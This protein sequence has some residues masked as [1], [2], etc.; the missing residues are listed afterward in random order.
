MRRVILDQ[1]KLQKER[2]KKGKLLEAINQDIDFQ[3]ERA[4][5]YQNKEW[6][7]SPTHWF[8]NNR[9]KDTHQIS[10]Y[11]HSHK[12]ETMEKYLE[13]FESRRD[14]FHSIT[15][16]SAKLLIKLWYAIE[17]HLPYNFK[18]IAS[19]KTF[20]R[21]LLKD[22]LHQDEENIKKKKKDQDQEIKNLIQERVKNSQF[23]DEG[24]EVQDGWL[25][26]RP[27]GSRRTENRI[28]PIYNF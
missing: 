6:K 7:T 11:Q 23:D 8:S 26:E 21:K 16:Y 3:I 14:D 4:T 5:K 18:N 24:K 28:N 20:L 25:S 1:Q 22:I 17:H 2:N 27:R 19:L 13:N 15:L 10:Q 9:N 12:L